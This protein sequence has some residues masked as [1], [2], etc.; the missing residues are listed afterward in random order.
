MWVIDWHWLRIINH[1]QQKKTKSIYRTH[2]YELLWI[3]HPKKNNS[4]SEGKNQYCA[5]GLWTDPSNFIQR[6]AFETLK[7]SSFPLARNH[8]F[9]KFEFSALSH[10]L[11]LVLFCCVLFSLFQIHLNVGYT[12]NL[13]LEIIFSR[14]LFQC[15]PLLFTAALNN[16]S[17]YMFAHTQWH[18]IRFGW[19]NFLEPES[20][21]FRIHQIVVAIGR[22]IE[23][24]AQ[25]TI[26]LNRQ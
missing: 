16:S 2:Y 10:I 3:T 17:V 24:P 26:H 25:F 4:R 8:M 12:N 1:L 13:C 6:A 14:A 21:V 22:G 7:C 19:N 11:I 9:T 5:G 20:S 23:G 18:S 15:F